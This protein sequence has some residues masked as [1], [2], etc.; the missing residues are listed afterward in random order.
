VAVELATTRRF[1]AVAIAAY[2]FSGTALPDRA[3]VLLK[4]IPFWVFHSADDVIFPVSYSDQ[5]V[6]SLRSVATA[7]GNGESVVRYTR[8]DQDQEGFT[9]SV[10]GHSTGITASKLPELYEWMLAL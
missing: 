7:S 9:G 6:R 8:Y 4:D 3:L 2:G 10:R 1:A 5:L